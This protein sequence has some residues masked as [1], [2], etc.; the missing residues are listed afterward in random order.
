MSERHFDRGLHIVTRNGSPAPSPYFRA[1]E[2]I[3]STGIYRVFHAGHRVSHEVTL[4]RDEAFPRC[5]TCGSEVHF[6]QLCCV[7]GIEQDADFRSRKLF[8]LPHPEEPQADPA[9]DPQVA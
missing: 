1:G 9:A 2:S 5:S 8:E 3:P 4:L 6:E 7:P